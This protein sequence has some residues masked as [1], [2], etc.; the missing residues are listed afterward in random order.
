MGG[1]CP[2]GANKQ[3]AN[4]PATLGS[5]AYAEDLGCMPVHLAGTASWVTGAQRKTRGKKG[6]GNRSHELRPSRRHGD[7]SKAAAGEVAAA[8]V[9]SAADSSDSSDIIG[10]MHQRSRHM[11]R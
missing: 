7:E 5:S 10:D 3:G 1:T 8:T 11:D 9:S 6:R 2:S 4:S